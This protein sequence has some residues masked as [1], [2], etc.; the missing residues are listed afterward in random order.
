MDI[1]LPREEISGIR[2]VLRHHRDD[3]AETMF[4]GVDGD[5]DRLR[6]FMPWVDI[7]KTVQDEERFIQEMHRTWKEGILFDFGIFDMKSGVYMGNIGVHSISWE[8]SHCELGYWIIGRFEGM[9]I[10]SEAVGVLETEMFGMGFNKVEIHC[11]T[12]NE[13]SRNIP[14]RLGYQLDGILRQQRM[15]HGRFVDDCVFSKLRSEWQTGQ[16]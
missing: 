6:Q 12:T 15:Q 13:R 1:R 11:D 16:D 7:V 8:H 2:I 3:L 10:I 4:A 5:R 14:G 9:G